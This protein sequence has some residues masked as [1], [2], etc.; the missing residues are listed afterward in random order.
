MPGSGSRSRTW[1]TLRWPHELTA[2]QTRAALLAL[3]ASSTRR[4]SDSLMLT[5]T[6]TDGQ[7]THQLGVPASRAS[8][9]R[10]QLE[11]AIRGLA[12]EPTETP[13]RQPI[14]RVW[15]CWASTRKR[16]LDTK[17]ADAVACALITALASAD[18]DELL[19]LSWVLGPV[20][21]AS[22][23]GAGTA[24][25]LRCDLG[26]VID[27]WVVDL[28]VGPDDDNPEAKAALALKQGSPGWRAALHLGVAASGR[29]RQRQLLGSL[30]SAAR[31]ADGAGV[32]LGFRPGC[33]SRAGE[34]RVPAWRPL[35]V[36]VD[37][38][39]GLSGWPIGDTEDLPVDSVRSR[40]LPP[41]RSV[42]SDGRVIGEATYP[43]ARRPCALA[44]GDA[45]QHLHVLGP[46]GTGKSTLLLNLICQD[47]T[48]GRSVVVIEPKGDLVTD[49]LARVPDHR[50]DDVVVIDPSDDTPVGINPLAAS[51]LAADLRVDHILTVFKKLYAESWGPRTQDI[52]TA[53]L[54]TLTKTP[55]MSLVAL[56]LLFTNPQF[57]QRLLKP[58]DDP[59]ALDP[60]WAWFEGLSAA[61]RTSVLAPVMNKLRAFLL[62]E[63]LR[64]VVGQARPR[65]DLR[66]IYRKRTVLLVNLALGI[67]GPESAAL[68]GSL[69][70]SQLWQTL[71]G[72]AAIP[73]ERRHPVMV[74]VD[75]FHSYVHL[76]TD[77]G[78]VL[79]QARGLGVGLTLAHQHLG[80]LAPDI[81]AAVLANARSRVLFGTNH[82]DA[83]T[84][85]HSIDRVKPADVVGLGRYEVYASLLS[86]SETTPYAS[87]RTLPPPSP[88]RPGDDVRERSR[89]RWGIPA[90]VIDVE[91]QA[92][93]AGSPDHQGEQEH[94]QNRALG[95]RRRGD[96][97]GGLS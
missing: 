83:L 15:R 12:V 47:M 56:P 79:T 31:M 27:D 57:R 71:L 87:V 40:L 55:G 54:L 9:I 72:R 19:V 28:M 75:E 42:P 90:E 33:R 11:A 32:Q 70:V 60:F 23:P 95:A 18:E 20:R 50:L 62:R 8:S 38:M 53:G 36:N 88:V 76:P 68:L 74:F 61:E 25:R 6:G 69:V 94:E 22:S 5:A 59:L 44:I 97:P 64:R 82:D 2:D 37:E 3:N 17:H 29:R 1:F 86:A 26:P 39:R 13:P 80:Q 41:T 35:L 49:V 93:A 78:E 58:V 81:H 45:L 77:L 96:E 63:R 84:I 52:L 43:T 67:L 46:T 66:D 21:R 24:R 4:R 30:A 65:F 92:L 7:V 85:M 73:Q 16:C 89:H 14:H 48:A 51:D 10:H 91:L 34:V